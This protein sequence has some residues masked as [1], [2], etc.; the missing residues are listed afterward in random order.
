MELLII[1]FLFIS[2]AGIIGAILLTGILLL[3]AWIYDKIQEMREK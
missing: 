3:F 2:C 1:Y